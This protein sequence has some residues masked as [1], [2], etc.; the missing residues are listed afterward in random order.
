M[1][2]V[3]LGDYHKYWIAEN[4]VNPQFDRYSS[5]ILALKRGE[6]YALEKFKRMVDSVIAAKN[7]VICYVP[8]CD[9]E[10]LNSGVK[11]LAARV[12]KNP[13]RTDGT[14]CIIRHT[15]IPKLAKGGA[16]SKSVHMESLKIVNQHI[17]EGK[18]VLLIDDVT[19]T[20]NSL[21]ACKELLLENGAASVYCLALGQ[22]VLE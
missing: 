22:T 15:T 5:S 17:I 1:P 3:H 10:K 2:I 19:T 20:N 21:L 4:V 13:Y 8:S 11:Q 9:K 16:R 12:S 6:E 14:S 7:I 18:Q